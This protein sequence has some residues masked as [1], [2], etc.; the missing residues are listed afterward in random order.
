MQLTGYQCDTC[1][2]EDSGFEFPIDDEMR[3]FSFLKPKVEEPNGWLVL[4]VKNNVIE[5]QNTVG[6]GGPDQGQ[7][8][9]DKSV[10]FHFCSIACLNAYAELESVVEVPEL[11]DTGSESA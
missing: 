9:V 10:T 7:H 6:G 2:T 1:R 3:A 8:V 11:E 5:W 4:V